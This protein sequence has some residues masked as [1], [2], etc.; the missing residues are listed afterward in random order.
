MLKGSPDHARFC[1][2]FLGHAP[3]TVAER[4]YARESTQLFDQ[5]MRWLGEQLGTRP[6]ELLT[7]GFDPIRQLASMRK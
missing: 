6:I 4:F 1:E 7:T 5:A 2:Y 3:A